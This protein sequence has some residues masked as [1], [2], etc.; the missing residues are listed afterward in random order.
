MHGNGSPGFDGRRIEVLGDTASLLLRI[1]PELRRGGVV[2]LPADTIYGLSC[3]W[4]SERA[5]ERIQVLK[6]PGRLSQFVSLVSSREMAFQYAEEPSSSGLRLLDEHWPGPLTAVLRARAGVTP[7]FC[8]GTEGTVAF[9]FPRSPFLQELVRDLG[10]PLVSTSANR[11]GEA[12]VESAQDA[13][14]VF[15][16]AIDL[17]VDAG[18]LSGVPSTL[19]DLTEDRPHLLRLGGVLPPELAGGDEAD[20]R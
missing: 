19:V 17:Y 13:W 16:G 15:G 6:G 9:R 4:D 10:V 20:A 11:T 18:P 12:P 3:R 2:F 7:E 5:L 1:L 14:G 8:A